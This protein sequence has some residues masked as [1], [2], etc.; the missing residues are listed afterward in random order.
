MKKYAFI[1]AGSANK[2]K[3][4]SL[5]RLFELL[6]EKADDVAI[7]VPEEYDIC[8]ILT[9]NGVRIG[10]DSLGDPP[11]YRT[12][13]SF[14]WFKEQDCQIIV[15]AARSY[16]WSYDQAFALEHDGYICCLLT[17]GKSNIREMQENLNNIYA[18]YVAGLIEEITRGNDL[19]IGE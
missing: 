8:A 18:K 4:K 12:V 1:N 14:N 7:G 9:I 19:N 11:Y 15:C 13:E 16:G 10:I 3:S 6:A 2:G 17:N 5:W